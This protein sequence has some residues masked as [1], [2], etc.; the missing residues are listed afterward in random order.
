MRGKTR[1]EKGERKRGQFAGNT[2]DM[3]LAPPVASVE[4]FQEASKIINFYVDVNVEM[5]ISLAL[6]AFGKR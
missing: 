4:L 6:L 1:D 2:D 3:K 5:F